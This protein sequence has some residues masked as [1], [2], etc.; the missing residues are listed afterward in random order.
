MHSRAFSKTV[1]KI[2]G[3]HEA[4]LAVHKEDSVV[5]V[6]VTAVF[7]FLHVEDCVINHVTCAVHVHTCIMKES[8]P[9][10]S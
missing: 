6:E 9:T 10:V 8:L 7:F 5:A 2:Q 1:K 3:A 4:L